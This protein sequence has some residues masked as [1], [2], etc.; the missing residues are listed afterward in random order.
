LKLELE[1][2]VEPKPKPRARSTVKS[3]KMITYTPKETRSTVAMIRSFVLEKIEDV[4]FPSE[5]P[6]K[7]EI[8]FYFEKPKSAPKRRTLPCVGA[9]FDNLA[10]M[11]T[12]A[13]EKY[14]Y[15]RDSQFTTVIIKKRYSS[16]P[17]IALKIEEDWI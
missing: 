16:P 6:L 4:K 3:G 9:D 17:R 11:C 15:H 7:M 13:L 8:T 12:D 1:I 5:M 10:K 14:L 2:P